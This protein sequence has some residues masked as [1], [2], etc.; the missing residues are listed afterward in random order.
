MKHHLVVARIKLKG[1]PLARLWDN[2]A[3]VSRGTA[4]LEEF[5]AYHRTQ[6]FQSQVCTQERE[7]KKTCPH[8]VRSAHA[9]S[10]IH[11]SPELETNQIN[12]HQ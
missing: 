1:Q 8:K 6:Q 3:G 5:G 4:T 11:N 7:K 9:Y 2:L 10:F 12:I